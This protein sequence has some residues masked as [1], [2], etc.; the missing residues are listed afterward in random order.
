[1]TGIG[2]DIVEN[3]RITE[4]V[5]QYSGRFLAKFLTREEISVW[6]KEGGNLLSLCGI[7]AA[8]EAVIKAVA[9]AGRFEINFA[10]VEIRHQANRIP[11]AVIPDKK[12]KILISISHEHNYTVAM[13]ISDFI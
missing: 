4:M 12:L 7:F 2:I 13:A 5:R 1:M 10:Q 3:A 9:C 8:K 6:K 11:F